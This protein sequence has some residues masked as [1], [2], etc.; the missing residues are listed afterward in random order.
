MSATTHLFR[1]TRCAAAVCAAL[2]VTPALA[3]QQGELETVTVTG[4]WLGSG[5]QNSVKNFAGARTVVQKEDI[6]DTGAATI[7]DV[8]RRIPG[9]QST[10]NSGSAGS[11]I[12]LNIGV[13][14]L[15]GRY[16][17]RSTVLLDGVPLAVAP[18]GQPHLSFAPVSLNNIESI[19]VVRG[20]G[21]VRYG[22]Q[23]VGGIINFT[24]RAI[25]ETP[26]ISGDASVRYNDFAEGGH[27]AQYSA[28]L[29]AQLD[30]GFGIALLYSGMDGTEWRAGSDEKVNDFALKF[31]WLLGKNAQVY[32]K[33]SYYDVTSKTPGGLTVAQYNANPFQNTRPTDYWDGDRKGIDLGYLNTLSATQEF[34]T[35]VY[36]NESSR[37]SSLINAARTSITNQ[38]RNYQVLGIEPRYTQRLTWGATTHDVTAGY[39]Y[40]RERGDD[41]TYSV[42]VA[43]GVQGALTTFDNATDAHAVYVDDRIAYGQWRVTP[44]VRFE[45][46]DSERTE[47]SGNRQFDTSNDKALPSLNVA[48]LATPALTVFSNYG[49]SFGP[50]QN[51]QLNSQ[52]AANPLKPELAKTVELGARWKANGL[53]AEGTL[54]RLRFDNQI[55]QVPGSNPAVFRNIGATKHEGIET[56]VDY[57]FGGALQGLD[58]YANWNYTKAIQES[59]TT[60]GLDVPFY[61]RRTATI[62]TRYALGAFSAGLSATAQSSQFSDAENTVQETANGGTGRIPGF[63]TVNAQVGWKLAGKPGVQLL[64]GLNNLADKR[65]Y[66]RNVDGN[67]GRMVG[68]PRTAYVQARVTF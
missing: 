1:L 54:Y 41:N 26:G 68:A 53:T 30:N 8:M 28:F 18:Y 50:V 6:E 16:S 11:A 12:S 14:G 40:L 60:A 64:A 23:N 33:L 52:T 29:A 47:R 67:A 36:Y 51:T 25:P 22:P 49:T 44:G 9:V 46:I 65:Y 7:G 32:G 39:R 57:R 62:G 56:A 2:A 19:D 5:L 59:G 24:T 35:K 4:N 48:Y 21:A 15:T 55:L 45:K 37:S 63:G 17:P 20:G 3:Q 58:V 13:R 42:A 10:D 34:E 38:P 66:T 31:R 61:S 43:T 27:N